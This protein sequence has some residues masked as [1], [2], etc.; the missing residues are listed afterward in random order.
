MKYLKSFR[1]RHGCWRIYFRRPG[2]KPR[3]LPVPPGYQGP[4]KPLPT[5]CLEFLAA[6]QE[7]MTEPLASLKPGEKRAA[8]GSVQWLVAEY[9]GSLDFTGRPKS[10]RVKHRKHIED[11]RVRRGERMVAGLEQVHFETRLAAMLDTPAA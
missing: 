10:V 11:F 6:Y 1:D 9:F 4:G 2:S 8:Y 3:P 5:D 7:A